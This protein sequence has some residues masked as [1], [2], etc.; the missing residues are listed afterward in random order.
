MGPPW[1]SCSAGSGAVCKALVSGT[2]FK[3]MLWLVR[4]N[5]HHKYLF[6]R[7]AQSM[8]LQTSSGP[9]PKTPQTLLFLF[10]QSV[11]ARFTRKYCF[12]SQRLHTHI[13]F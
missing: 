12:V 9:R 13:I 5:G 11:F 10:F 4:A 8:C 6:N 7:S 1:V 3:L 2:M